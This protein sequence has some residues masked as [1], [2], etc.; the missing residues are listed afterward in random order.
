MLYVKLFENITV[1]K[2]SFHSLTYTHS[3]TR[4]PLVPLV[5]HSNPL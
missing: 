4:N 2:Y 1:G 3:L 5:T